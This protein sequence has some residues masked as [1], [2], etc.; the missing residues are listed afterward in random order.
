MEVSGHGLHGINIDPVSLPRT[1]GGLSLLSAER[2]TESVPSFNTLRDCDGCGLDGLQSLD[3]PRQNVEGC[4]PENSFA[5]AFIVRS[6][7]IAANINGY[8]VFWRVEGI[9]S[10]VDVRAPNAGNCFGVGEKLD[11]VRLSYH[12]V[13]LGRKLLS[14]YR[15]KII[16]RCFEAIT[17]EGSV[18]WRLDTGEADLR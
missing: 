16:S 8:L 5:C 11:I 2:S 9:L 7:K 13:R 15:C 14:G 6:D 12:K 1:N 18:C 4:G 10:L 3:L 17:L